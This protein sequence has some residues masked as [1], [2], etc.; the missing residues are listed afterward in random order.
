MSHETPS[1]ESS[2][3]AEAS[4]PDSPT[5]QQ[6]TELLAAGDEVTTRHQYYYFSEVIFLVSPFT[7]PYNERAVPL[8]KDMQVEG[9]LFK[10][11]RES[12]VENSELF[13][14]MFQLPVPS[15]RSPD[16]SSDQNPLRLDGIEK[17]D[18]LQLL[19][20]MFPRSVEQN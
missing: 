1:M 5:T 15:G 9:S 2:P 16:G 7:T 17:T 10:V 3:S 14:A 4:P 18:F 12:F 8:T 20:V 19:K 13:R 11:P 6:E